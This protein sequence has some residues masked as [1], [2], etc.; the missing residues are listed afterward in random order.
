MGVEPTVG[1]RIKL[2][3]EGSGRWAKSGGEKSKFGLGA[4]RAD[5]AARPSCERLGRKDILKLVHFHLGS[6]ITDIRY[7]KAGLEEIGRYYVE[8]RNMGFD[9]TPRGRG[10]R[11]R[12]GLRRLALD[13][14]GEHELLACGSTRTT[15]CTPSGA[16][17]ATEELPMPH[18]I[19]RIRARAHRAP[20]AA[21]DQ[22]HRRRVA[23][24]AGGSR[25]CGEDRTR[26]CVEMA[27]N[28]EALTPDRRAKRCSTTPCSPRSARR[29]CSPAASSRCATAP[30]PSSSTSPR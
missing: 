6:Q 29:S 19:S 5:E 13:P 9:M 30:T 11:A 28:L 20:R 14:A 10:R 24:R 15:W 26:C 22:R 16:S 27:D 8:L 18:L 4:G 7:I 25:G 2:A 21:A 23:G 12:R 17:A 1:V 3:T